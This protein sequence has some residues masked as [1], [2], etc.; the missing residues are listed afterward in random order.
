MKKPKV[1][2]LC[3]GK[4]TRLREETEIKPKPL[5]QIGEKP[6]L[7]HI[8]KIYSRF[9]YSDFILCLGYKGEMIKEYF[10]NYQIIMNDFTIQLE[11]KKL[12]LH[13]QNQHDESKWSVSLIDTGLNTLKGTRIK[14]IEEYIN[15]D[16]FL[17]TYGDGVADIDIDKLV[18]FHM[19]HGKIGT[20]T[21]VRPPS[22]FGDLITKDEKVV[23]FTEK[24]QASAGLINGGFFVF[25]KKV[26]DYLS[27]D[28]N[29]DFEGKA[30]ERLAED[31]QLMVYEH[32]GSWECMD[33]YRD[34]E[35]LNELWN[36][37]KA[38]WKTW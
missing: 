14:K 35:H 28:E 23:K 30:L 37:N 34:T 15:E 8:M 2:I 10:Y 3:G 11:S 38:F 27:L 7:W 32:K 18:D 22:R 33:T 9:G 24:P 5:I 13:R 20:L 4:G 1:V 16:L 12:V 25:N 6:I 31:G 29:C 26:F 36:N 21:G 17:L 19:N